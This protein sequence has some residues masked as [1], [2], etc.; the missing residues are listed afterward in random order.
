MKIVKRT[1]VG[2]RFH[3]EYPLFVPEG[4]EDAALAERFTETLVSLVL[5]RARRE[6]ARRFSLTYSMSMEGGMTRIEYR[7]A[8]SEM[9]RVVAEKKLSVLWKGGLIKEFKNLP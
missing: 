9:R 3:A 1:L 5:E 6:A 4:D 2:R 8:A 7:L